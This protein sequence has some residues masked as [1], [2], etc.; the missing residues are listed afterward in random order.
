[1]PDS[2]RGPGSRRARHS[3]QSSG[4]RENAASSHSRRRTPRLRRVYSR[5][6]ADAERLAPLPGHEKTPAAWQTSKDD[7]VEKKNSAPEIS[8]AASDEKTQP[9]EAARLEA[10]INSIDQIVLELDAEGTF[11][12]IWANDEQLLYHPAKNCWEEDP[13]TFSTRIFPLFA[14][15]LQARD[16]HRQGRRF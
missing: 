2:S 14:R 10:L 1:M 12:S 4:P 3:L 16:R 6:L 8:I 11:L 5:D 13:R 7:P 9:L 15:A